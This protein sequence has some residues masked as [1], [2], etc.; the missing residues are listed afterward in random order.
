LRG[1]AETGVIS[2]EQEGG[3]RRTVEAFKKHKV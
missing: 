1:I 3:L 2:E